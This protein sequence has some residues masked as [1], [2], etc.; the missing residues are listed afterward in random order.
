MSYKINDNDIMELH[1]F[2]FNSLFNYIKH[3]NPTFF[4]YDKEYFDAWLS[5]LKEVNT[6]NELI[7]V[8]YKQCFEY[9]LVL[10]D[11]IFYIHFDYLN[12][13][14]KISNNSVGFKLAKF[15]SNLF[16]E[17]KVIWYSKEKYNYHHLLTQKPILLTPINFGN[18]NPKFIIIDGNHRVSA[19]ADYNFLFKKINCF[20]YDCLQLSDFIFKA[21]YLMWSFFN[22]LNNL[23]NSEYISYN[24]LENS[25]LNKIRNEF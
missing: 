17:N 13:L 7:N 4:H 1:Y 20:I 23:F 5:T 3:L 25:C 15:K 22:E 21:D 8:E 6:T 2:N 19:K 18:N 24:L 16:G 10:N 9:P 14:E 12:I 11:Q